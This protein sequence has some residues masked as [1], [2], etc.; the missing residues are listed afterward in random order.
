MG[1]TIL[2][3]SP[4]AERWMRFLRLE[5][6]FYV[7]FFNLFTKIS[8]DFHSNLVFKYLVLFFW[9]ITSHIFYSYIFSYPNVSHLYSTKTWS[10]NPVTTKRKKKKSFILQVFY[11]LKLTFLLMLVYIF[12][13]FYKNFPKNLHSN[14]VIKHL[15]LF[16]WKISSHIFYTYAFP[17]PYVSY[18]LIY[19]IKTWFGNPA[20]TKRKKM[21]CNLQ[22]FFDLKLTFFL[23]LVY[24]F[25]CSTSSFFQFSLSSERH[26]QNT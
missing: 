3:K 23:M 6:I 9:K 19:S 16:F 24:I 1:E 21:S 26:S 2:G 20:I 10:G 7:Q 5:A 25:L 14:L 13:S 8:K 18:L 4:G 17:Y 22:V 15:V 11:D 12:Q